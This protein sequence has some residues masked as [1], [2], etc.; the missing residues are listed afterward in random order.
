MGFNQSNNEPHKLSHFVKFNDKKKSISDKS[1]SNSSEKSNSESGSDSD[2]SNKT[3]QKPKV[4]F[5][6]PSKKSEN[7]FNINQN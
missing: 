6:N 5:S 7:K 2:G 1:S 3:R 4:G